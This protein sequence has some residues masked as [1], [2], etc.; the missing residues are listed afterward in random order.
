MVSSGAKR[1]IYEFAK[2]P[3]SP[4]RSCP[5]FTIITSGYN[6]RKDNGGNRHLPPDGPS[7]QIGNLAV[8][9]SCSGQACSG[10]RLLTVREMKFGQFFQKLRLMEL[11]VGQATRR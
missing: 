2:V 6:L 5:G 4:S 9:L 7:S 3:L 8:L 11:S 1:V 10:P